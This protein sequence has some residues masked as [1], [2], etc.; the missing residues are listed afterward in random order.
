ML[1]LIVEMGF[2]VIPG[3]NPNPFNLVHYKHAHALP[4]Y[5]HV[6]GRVFSEPKAVEGKRVKRNDNI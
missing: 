1:T 2:S 6:R 5:Y 3:V 4:S